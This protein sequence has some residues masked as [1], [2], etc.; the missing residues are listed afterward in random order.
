MGLGT[1]AEE[2]PGRYD[3]LDTS[4]LDGKVSMDSVP[5]MLPCA[6]LLP[7]L[8]VLHSCNVQLSMLCSVWVCIPSAVFYAFW[9]SMRQFYMACYPMHAILAAL[10]TPEA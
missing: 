2:R 1:E 10:F 7:G 6:S 5:S 4:D 9:E 3:S 8:I